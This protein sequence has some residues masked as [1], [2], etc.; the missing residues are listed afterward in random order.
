MTVA[1][2]RREAVLL[3]QREDGLGAGALVALLVHVLLVL[4]LAFGVNWHA[5]EPEG[6]TA[7]LWAAVPQVAAPPAAE[8]PPPPEPVKAE[9]VKPAPRVVKEEPVPQKAQRDAEIAI[10]KAKREKEKAREAEEERK[11]AEREKA[12]K[13][14]AEKDKLAKA[15]ADAEADKRK[16]Q[17]ED[18]RQAKLREQLRQQQLERIMGQ[19]GGTGTPTSAGTAARDA[20]PSASYAGKVRAAIEPRITWIHTTEGNPV[21][22]VLVR[23]ALDGTIMSRKITK[24]SGNTDWDDAVLDAI[25]KTGRLPR[26]EDGRVP[27][28]IIISFRPKG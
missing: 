14:K 11:Q 22:E 9:P 2:V 20:G 5:S 3:P 4:G 12:L 15:K 19:V 24:S 28:A 23:A 26:D 8:P 13:E 10:E 7:E 1:I 25:D 18:A 6:V 21:A 17:E 16:K 27:S